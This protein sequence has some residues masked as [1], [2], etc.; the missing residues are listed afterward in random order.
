[1]SGLLASINTLKFSGKVIDYYHHNLINKKSEIQKESIE[2]S[3][4]YFS[5]LNFKNISFSYPN[6]EKLLFKDFNVDLKKG[7][8]IQIKG[9]T[10]S[11]K[12]TL[13][14]II[15]GLQTPQSYKIYMDGKELKKF[16]HNWLENFSYVPQSIYLF[17]TSIK[18]NI[19]MEDN[20]DFNETLF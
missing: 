15:L 4:K 5:E 6:N 1:M 2:T 11:G 10:G 17:D 9:P 12:S 3:K 20:K 16:P 7:E 13:I 8:I 18:N 14:D 19:T